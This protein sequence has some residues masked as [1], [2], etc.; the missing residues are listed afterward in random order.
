MT[1]AYRRVGPLAELWNGDVV[2]ARVD[3]IKLVLVRVDD[4]V[5]AYED[6]C[7]HLGVELSKGT[8]DGCVLTC[9]AHHWQYD[10]RS[11]RGINPAHACLSRFPI[12]IEDGMIYVKIDRCA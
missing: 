10:V 4:E 7:A 3:G 11:G 8:L 1:S 9:S 5:H 2:A 6:R 12:K